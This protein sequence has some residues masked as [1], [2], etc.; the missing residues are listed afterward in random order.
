MEQSRQLQQC[1]EALR[2]GES[3]GM[4]SDH[5]KQLAF[6]GLALIK[7]WERDQRECVCVIMADK[8][9][10]MDELRRGENFTSQKQN[11]A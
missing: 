8:E 9:I 7:R 4:W 5:A 10:K 2:D 3:D 11:N 6:K 1:G